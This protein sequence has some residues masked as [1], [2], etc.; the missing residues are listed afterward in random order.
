MRT[1]AILGCALLIAG[2][3]AGTNASVDPAQT[4]D[5]RPVGPPQDCVRISRIRSTHVRDDRTIDFVLSGG[6]TYRNVLPNACP[7]LGFERS[8]SYGSSLSRLCS[9]DIIT[10]VNTS[11]GPSRGAGCGLGSFQR[12]DTPRR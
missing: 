4:A 6:E 2:C 10:V 3:N 12:I 9:V 11:G 1:I 5:A 8:F 7:G